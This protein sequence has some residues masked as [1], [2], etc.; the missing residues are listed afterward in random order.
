MFTWYLLCISATNPLRSEKDQSISM[1]LIIDA[2]S[3]V[4]VYFK[5]LSLSPLYPNHLKVAGIIPYSSVLNWINLADTSESPYVY[6]IPVRKSIL[7]FGLGYVDKMLT[8]ILFE[9]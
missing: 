3:S 5:E 1:N 9:V 2:L 7:L 6:Q 4:K 8:E